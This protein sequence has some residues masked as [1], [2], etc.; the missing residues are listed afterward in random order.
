MSAPP[1]A[2]AFLLLASALQVVSQINTLARGQPDNMVGVEAG[3]I[4]SDSGQIR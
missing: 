2:L 4:I 3:A 1:L